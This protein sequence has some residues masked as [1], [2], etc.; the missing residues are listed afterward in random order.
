MIDINI[1][2]RAMLVCAVFELLL[3]AAAHVSPWLR[4]HFLLFGCMM[5]AGVMGL[6]YGRDLA[7]GFRLGALGGGVIGAAGGIVAVGASSI[8]GERPDLDIPYGVML[9]AVVGAIGGLFGQF[10]AMLRKVIR[11]LGK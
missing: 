5:I 6:L 4:L 2:R 11:S 9:L 10:D 1:L 7:R 8:L 3:V